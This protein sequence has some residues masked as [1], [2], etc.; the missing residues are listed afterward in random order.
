VLESLVPAL[1]AQAAGEPLPAHVRTVD[2]DGVTRVNLID[3]SPIGVN[4]RSTS[5]LRGRTPLAWLDEA[6][7]ILDL[8][9]ESNAA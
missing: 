2:A 1:R 5:G 7:I 9:P 6:V 4:V 8:D 3:A